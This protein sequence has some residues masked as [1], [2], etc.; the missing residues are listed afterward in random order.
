MKILVITPYVS[1]IYGGVATVV[2]E[3]VKELG[4]LNV[5]VDL[6]TT[7]ANDSNT[8]DVPLDTWIY[9]SGYRVRYF[10]S[11][12]INDFIVSPSL[13]Y[14]LFKH[15][16]EYDLVHTHAIFAPLISAAQKV[17]QFRNVPYLATPHGMLEPWAL[18]YKA[19]KKRIYYQ[20]LENST[21]NSAVAVQALTIAESNQ[22]KALGFNH[23]V[24]VPNGICRRDFEHSSNP[25][26]FYQHFPRTR[27]KILIL[28]LG[29]LD[30]KKGLDLLA[31]AFAKVH[32]LFPLTHLVIAGPDSIGFLPTVEKYFT[33]VGCLDATTVTGMITG[34]LKS[35]ALAAA[36]LYVAPSYSEGFSVSV[37]EAMAS[38]LP[39]VI[40]T[41]CNFPEALIAHAAHVVDISADAITDALIH[42]LKYPDEAKAMGDRAQQLIIENY[43]WDKIAIRMIEV[44]Q[45]I[46]NCQPA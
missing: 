45:S 20:F 18:G 3:I 11:W 28:F 39:C 36:D 29:R 16:A 4:A 5:S 42:C 25:E 30:P 23:A 44:Y 9:C 17:C 2:T 12:N 21:L 33:Q 22:L 27:N 15:V 37:L 7:H 34:S 40:T 41:S 10:A 26:T 24:V 14:W 31:P 19:W 1:S 43:T 8:L 13:I 46:L 32:A 35:G 38:G 6:I